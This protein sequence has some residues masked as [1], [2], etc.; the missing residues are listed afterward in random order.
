MSNYGNIIKSAAGGR[1]VPAF[2][3]TDFNNSVKEAATTFTGG[4]NQDVLPTDVLDTQSPDMLNMWYKDGMLRT[5]PGI[6][7]KTDVTNK[8]KATINSDLISK[9]L[10]IDTPYVPTIY[11]NC[12]NRGGGNANE[13]RNI[14]TPWVKVNYSPSSGNKSF[15]L[16]DTRI[17]YDYIYIT[18]RCP[19]YTVDEKYVIPPS[20]STAGKFKYQSP[21][22]ST[23][24]YYQVNANYTAGTLTWHQLNSNTWDDYNDKWVGF[25]DDADFNVINNLTV[26][27]SKTLY[28]GSTDIGAYVPG[29]AYLV[30]AYA[31]Y[32]STVYKC[33][34]DNTDETFTLSHWEESYIV[35]PIINCTIAQYYGGSLSGLGNGDCLMVT[36]NP[37]EPNKYWW[38]GTDDISYWPV[39]NFNTCGDDTDPITAFAKQSSNLIAFTA[40]KTYKITYNATQPTSS[41]TPYEPFPRSLLHNTI[42]CDCPDTIEL[43]DNCLTWLNSDGNIYRL[44]TISNTSETAIVAI[45]QNI[46]LAVK[47]LS[48]SQLQAATSCDTG[49]YYIIFAEKSAFAWDYDAI[50]FIN[51]TSTEKSQSRLAWYLWSMPAV[52]TDAFYDGNIELNGGDYGMDEALGSDLGSTFNAY[53]YTKSFDFSAVTYYKS[54]YQQCFK[55]LSDD[56]TLTLNVIDDYGTVDLSQTFSVSTKP[57]IVQSYQ[58]SMTQLYQAYI[59]RPSGSTAKFAINEFVAIAQI[60]A[61]I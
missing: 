7:L 41:S 57:Q 58:T 49:R 12:N 39:N 14:I 56:G 27:Y 21:N 47:K 33:T 16:P 19:L 8:S 60:A 30:G 15:K 22:P 9:V 50:S 24:V 10:D 26:K 34:V 53:V 54:V 38:S 29:R 40:N 28:H 11:T 45:N 5:R 35:N 3:S 55:V 13:D 32:K 20:G 46:R 51:Y 59:S 36:G 2:N 25:T 17:D 6:V 48:T 61:K 18:Y 43:V 37:N 1:S 23:T 4:I 42:G 44:V 31:L 52:Y